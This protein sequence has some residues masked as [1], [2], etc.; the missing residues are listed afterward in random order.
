MNENPRFVL[1]RDRVLKKYSELKDLDL[2]I[3]YS[4]KT[5]VEVGEILENETDSMFSVHSLRELERVEDKKRVW[6]FLLGNS[7]K[8]LEVIWRLGVRNFVVDLIDDLNLLEKFIEH[9]KEKINLLLRINLRENTIFSGRYYVFGMKSEIVNKKIPFLRENESIGKLGIHFHRKTQNVSEWN[10]KEDLENFLSKENLE[11][12]DII[13]IG[14][15]LPG[16]YKNTN[17]KTLEMIFRKIL[18]VKEEFGKEIIVEP[19][20]FIAS[21]SVDLECKI[22]AIQGKTIFVNCSIFNSSLDTI[23][24][25]VKLLVEGEKEEGN[26]YMIK[27]CT[28]ASE[29]IF[30]YEVYLE[31]PKV[32]DILKFLNAGAYNYSSDFCD[33]EKIKT[34]VV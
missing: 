15:G 11:K 23:I 10:L 18:E 8:Y 26:K 17:D 30:R 16:S 21:N 27:G 31:N 22:I 1:Y 6:Y 7:E 9:K 28:P 4:L 34:I 29:D 20:R 25:N 12:I 5:N 14:G 2:K 19:G 3:S 13:N 24:A 32:G 33:L